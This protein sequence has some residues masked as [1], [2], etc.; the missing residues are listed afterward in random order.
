MKK[1]LLAGVISAFALPAYAQTCTTDPTSGNT[2]CDPST[3]HVSSP[4]ASGSDPVLLNEGTTFTV[5]E[6]GNK[7][8]N[9]PIRVFF[10]SPLGSALPTISAFSG[11]SAG[12]AFN[13]VGNVP[14]DI[15]PLTFDATNGLFDGPLLGTLTAGQDF[16]KQLGIGGGSVSF[17]NFLLAYAAD[18]LLAPNAFQIDEAIF[19]VPGGGFNSDADFLTV[20]GNFG[21]GTIIAPVAVDV[22]INPHNGKLDITTYDSPWTETAFVNATVTPGVPEPSTWAM[23]VAGFGLLG[24]VGWKKRGARLAI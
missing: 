17:T 13:I 19:N 7:T 10:L 20:T 23:L 3:L 8:I 22:S 21:I 6:V 14:I 15:A 9:D 5:T 2:I 18:N 1:L 12:G 11:V 24:L 4:T 16:G